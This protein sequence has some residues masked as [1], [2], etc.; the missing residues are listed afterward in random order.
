MRAGPGYDRNWHQHRRSPDHRRDDMRIEVRL[1]SGL[2]QLAG[3]SRLALDVDDGATVRDVLVRVAR[4]RPALAGGLPSALTVV[5][6]T[7]VGAERALADGDE[8]AVL[9]PVAGG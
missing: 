6:G 9:T 1:G 2:S 8:V 7:Q 4:E 5:G 3:G